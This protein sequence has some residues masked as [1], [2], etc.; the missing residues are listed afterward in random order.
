MSDQNNEQ[1][2][3][4]TH[5]QNNNQKPPAFKDM[6]TKKIELSMSLNLL[7]SGIISWY[8]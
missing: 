4:K 7:N 1:K 3:K 5:P 6:F 2:Q 8:Y